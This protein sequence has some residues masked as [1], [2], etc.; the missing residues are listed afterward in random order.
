VNPGIPEEMTK[1]DSDEV[2]GPKQV[3]E[4][5]I[6]ASADPDVER[7]IQEWVASRCTPERL[8]EL[9]ALTRQPGKSN[10][11]VG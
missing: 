1:Q 9:A 4:L 6:L 10:G 11:S 5:L 3:R 2:L 8:Q 7:A